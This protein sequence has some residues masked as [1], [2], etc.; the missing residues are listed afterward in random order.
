MWTTE[1]DSVKYTNQYLRRELIVHFIQNREDFLERVRKHCKI[2]L[3]ASQKHREK[4]ICI[5][6]KSF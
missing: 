6:L 1:E 5:I 4:S 3:V 2:I